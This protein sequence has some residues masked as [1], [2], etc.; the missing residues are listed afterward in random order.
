MGFCNL[1][2]TLSWALI[3]SIPGALSGHL[4]SEVTLLILPHV[5]GSIHVHADTDKETQRST[6]IHAHT[7]I[8]FPISTVI[9]LLLL[10]L[11][12]MANYSSVLGLI[13]FIV[14]IIH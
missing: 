4:I 14:N 9:F 2:P 7:V 5:R 13:G 6:H 11:W 1:L 12:V 3:Y 10:R 8:C